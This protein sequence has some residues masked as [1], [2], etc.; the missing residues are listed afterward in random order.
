MSGPDA[1]GNDRVAARDELLDELA[2]EYAALDELLRQLSD[3]DW[4]RPTPA[5]GW[6]VRDQVTHL[7]FFDG[8]AARSVAEPQRFAVEEERASKDHDAYHDAAI[9]QGR[10]RTPGEV[11]ADWREQTSAFRSAASVA[12]PAMRCRWFVTQMGLISLISARLMETWAHGQDVRDTIGQ[13]PEISDRLRHVAFLGCNAM[14]YAFVAN[15]LDRPSAPVRVE[16]ELPSGQRFVHGPP[17][18]DDRVEGSALDFC[19]LATQRRHADDLDLV[20][21]G[22]VAEAWLPI[23]QA[24]AGPPG[25]GRA[26]GQFFD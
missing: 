4:R 14:P 12:D 8:A 3:D 19:L 16:L 2:A 23:C 24:F 9:E 20:A 11:L 21:S 1:A 17:D 26:P 7:A 22:P 10:Q 15:G 5:A 18:A 25:P 6:D 13:P